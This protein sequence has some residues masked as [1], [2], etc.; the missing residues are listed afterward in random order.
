MNM[1]ATLSSTSMLSAAQR[2]ALHVGATQGPPHD[3]LALVLYARGGADPSTGFAIGALDA[4]EI[5]ACSR[6]LMLAPSPGADRQLTESS[7]SFGGLKSPTNVAVARNGTVYL[8]DRGNALIKYFDPCDCS[9]KPLPCFVA[10]GP[11]AQTDGCTPGPSGFA[12]LNQLRDPTGLAVADRDLVIVDRGHH[13]V[14]LMDL[15]GS[16]PRAA[17]RLPAST[18]LRK[19]WTPFAVAVDSHGHIYASDPDHAR[20]D[21]F[22]RDARWHKAW[23]GLGQVTHLAVDANDVVL[24]VIEDIDVDATGKTVPGAFEIVD[25]RRRP[26]APRALA[27]ASRFA[28]N[29]IAVDP[30]GRLHLGAAC[31]TPA[32]AVFDPQGY[33][34]KEKDK[35]AP[36]L[37]A[38]SGSYRSSALDSR[39]RGC[40]WH[41]V[42]LAGALPDHTRIDL[43]TTTS[44]VELDAGEL[45]DLPA[46]AWSDAVSVRA[47]EGGTTD[48]LVRSPPGRYLWL[49]LVLSGDGQSTPCISHIV[50]EFPRISL[51]R[52][53]PG[54]YGMDPI[55]ADFTDR[56]TAL[57]DATLRSIETRIDTMHELFDPASAPADKPRAKTRAGAPTVDFLSWLAGW[58]GV[59]FD[60]GW[61]EATRRA[62]L[63]RS[64]CL[65]GQRGTAEGLR[66]L[67]L[68]F[69]GFDRAR[70]E[71]AC[72]QPRCT[73]R[74]DN[75]APPPRP[76]APPSPPLILE[77]FRLRR[78]LFVGAGRLG[79]DAMIWGKR[80]V[81]RSELS[82]AE[83]T[84]NARV[85]PLSCPPDRN[86]ATQLI[87][88]PDPQRD[89]FHVYA[90]QFSVFVPARVKRSEWQR[91]GLE[92][93]LAQESP[94]HTRWQI[95]YVE[96]RFRVGVQAMVG[97][98]SVI[99][100][101]PKGIRL[102]DNRLGR[103]SVL[104]PHPGRPAVAGIDARVGETMRLT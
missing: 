24:A 40:V 49:R 21:I 19:L 47:L 55:G 52:Y 69:L 11:A 38:T 90:H 26:L 66:Q 86:P 103:G 29:R 80:I 41:R 48:A 14:V 22:G 88:T 57:F 60:R 13:R 104:P 27:A 76:C 75:C 98:D 35:V 31:A 34:V 84:G 61:P 9:F 94:G 73:P 1:H 85:G 45:A 100:R 3:P 65:F 77:H 43:Q 12:P 102:N 5:G 32:D 97:L 82:G 2:A 36:L 8:V 10:Q 7:G 23:T 51:R 79:D 83:R 18:G 25:G 58:V 96:P 30:A 59:A 15:I 53:L 28:C 71:A 42:Q 4:V 16:V 70:C 33:P 63:K 20:I 101:V 54:V 44:D 62:I 93:L 6:A 89:P 95:E 87:S 81:N 99:A 56:F 50:I 17:L 92:R 37:Y 46:Q 72:P 39:R 91:R 67:L 68:T 74:P 64:A 78:W